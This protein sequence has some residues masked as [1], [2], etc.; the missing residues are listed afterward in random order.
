MDFRSCSTHNKKIK[1]DKCPED[2]AFVS[3]AESYLDFN[4]ALYIQTAEEV[5]SVKTFANC[6]SPSIKEGDVA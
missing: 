2:E 4:V 6:M 1:Y 3:T 5:Y